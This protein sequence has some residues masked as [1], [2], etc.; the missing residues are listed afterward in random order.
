[1]TTQLE[2]RGKTTKA[3]SVSGLPMFGKRFA[4]PEIAIGLDI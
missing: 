3:E 2:E 4:E 1:M